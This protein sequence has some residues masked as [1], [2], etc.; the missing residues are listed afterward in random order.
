MFETDLLF[1]KQVC[2]CFVHIPET[3]GFAEL[4]SKVWFWP[5]A[6]PGI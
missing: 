2:S 6:K 5:A 3:G 4:G 1:F